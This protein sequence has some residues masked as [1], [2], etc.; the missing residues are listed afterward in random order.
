MREPPL[1]WRGGN[2]SECPLSE[3]GEHF[4]GRLDLKGKEELTLRILFKFFWC[5]GEC[6]RAHY[7]YSTAPPAAQMQLKNS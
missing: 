4:E 3:Q 5:R 2:E 6:I 1:A 7:I